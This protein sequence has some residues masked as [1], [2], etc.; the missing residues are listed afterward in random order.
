MSNRYSKI[1]LLAIFGLVIILVLILNEFRLNSSFFSQKEAQASAVYYTQLEQEIS[2][3]GLPVGDYIVGGAAEDSVLQGFTHYGLT[4]RPV[5]ED[6]TGQKFTKSI[7]LE[8]KQKPKFYNTS[9]RFNNPKTVN[10]GDV[11]LAVINIK[12]DNQSQG[13]VLMRYELKGSPYTDSF[14]REILLDNTWKTLY[15][16]FK[17]VQ[18]YSPNKSLFLLHLGYQEQAVSVGGVALMNFG[19]KVSLSDLEVLKTKVTYAGRESN[20]SWRQA[21]QDRIE[22]IRKADMRFQVVD[23]TDKPINCAS[24]DVQMQKHKYGFGS[25]VGYPMHQRDT[26]NQIHNKKIEEL[27][28]HVA[29]T[30]YWFDENNNT[31]K[32]LLKTLDWL[33]EKGITARRGHNL[34]WP[35]WQWMPKDMKN[36]QNNPTYLKQRTNKWIVNSLTILKGRVLSWDVINEPYKSRDLMDILGDDVMKD[37]LALAKKTDPK[38]KVFVNEIDVI[39]TGVFPSPAYNNLVKLIQSWQS[40]NIPIEGVGVQGHFDEGNLTQPEI[41]LKI[42]DGLA[43][44]NLDIQITEYDFKSTDEQLKADYTRDIMTVAFSHPSTSDF[45]MW[46]FWDGDHWKD[47]APLFYKD[48]TLKPAGKAW[49]DLVHKQWWTNEQGQ[50]DNQGKYS[51]RGF[52]GDYKITVKAGA[53][54]EMFN[55]FLDSTGIDSNLKLKVKADQVCR[56]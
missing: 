43:A 2:A 5:I 53:S 4:T 32:N 14:N 22:R 25:V 42:F 44:Y 23:S 12:L 54:S 41:L 26:D 3:K 24:V 51:T 7:R 50:V 31:Q 13:K 17:A 39:E 55:V 56:Q 35:A 52:L 33:D 34:I 11:L 8:T 30:Q 38:A 15:F 46:G 16:T 37:W 45:I 47:D 49:V 1:K 21:A 9:W 48:W 6:V 29:V 28:N 20:T 40:D 19:T 27:F 10:K 36:H 18:D